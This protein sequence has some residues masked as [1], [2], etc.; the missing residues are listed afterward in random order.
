MKKLFKSHNV[1]AVVADLS[2]NDQ[3]IWKELSEMGKGGLPVNLVYPAKPGEGPEE[4]PTNLSTGILERA[5]EKAAS[6]S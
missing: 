5:I 1:V 2:T 4:L 3:R 6:S